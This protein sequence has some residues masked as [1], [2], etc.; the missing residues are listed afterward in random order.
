MKLDVNDLGS[1]LTEARLTGRLDVQGALVI[2]SEFVELANNCK[3]LLI[4][5][6]GLTFLASLGIRTLVQAAK[7]LSEKNG[8][9]ALLSPP[10]NVEGILR[11]T[12]I[13]TV[14]P[15]YHARSEALAFLGK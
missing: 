13:D 2:D 11:A 8:R 6:S 12:G 1:G 10:S 14:I 7:S 9:V 3:N 15:I 4:D 5:L